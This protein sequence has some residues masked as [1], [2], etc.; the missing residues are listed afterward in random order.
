MKKTLK[1]I[2]TLV[3]SAAVLLSTLMCAIPVT[4]AT[5]DP[6]T[7]FMVGNY[8]I[9]VHYLHNKDTV[10]AAV[11][12]FKAANFAKQVNDA[13]AKWALFTLTQSNGVYNIPM[14]EH[15]DASGNAIFADT[16]VTVAEG[17][18]DIVE[19]LYDALAP[20]GIKLMLYWIP[21]APK[22][23]AEKATLLGATERVNGDEKDN[24]KINETVANNMSSIM[25]S[26]SD[27]YG[28]KVA[29]WWIDGCYDS[30]GFND[31]IATQEAAALRAG[32]ADALVAFNRGTKQHDAYY[33][34]ESYAAGEICHGDRTD[35]SKPNY[36]DIY[37]FSADSR[38]TDNGFQ[39]HYLTFLGSN[40]T[41]GDER[42]ET[43]EMVDHVYN[44]ILKN[45]GAMTFDM[46]CF[47]DGTLDKQQYNQMVALSKVV[48][49]VVDT[50]FSVNFEKYN[51][52][53]LVSNIYN[54]EDGKERDHY[55]PNSNYISV[56]TGEAA[57]NGNASLKVVPKDGNNRTDILAGT[58]VANAEA[59][60]GIGSKYIRFD[61][62]PDFNKADAENDFDKV[63]G[64]M[65]RVKIAN[66]TTQTAH[67]FSVYTYQDEYNK[68]TVLGNGAIAYD[69][70][71]NK[72]S[73]ATGNLRI[74]LPAGFDGFVFMPF[75]TAQSETV[76]VAG[77]YDKY[78][79]FPQNLIDFSNPFR[80]I[81]R[82]NDATWSGTEVYLDDIGFYY[83]NTDGDAWDTMRA[84]GYDVIN[85][86]QP[87]VY[88][89]PI[90][91]ENLW[92][93]ISGAK[94][95]SGSSTKW[96]LYDNPVK[97]TSNPEEVLNGKYSI[98][99]ST[100]N[101]SYNPAPL[102]LKLT[103]NPFNVKGIASLST[104]TV[105][106]K[107]VDSYAYLKVRVKVPEVASDIVGIIPAIKQNGSYWAMIKNVK[108]Y[109]SDGTL[110]SNV[111]NDTYQIK[112]PSGFDGYLYLPVY[113]MVS[114]TYN[115]GD[116]NL[117]PQ[118]DYI[119]KTE[120]LTAPDLDENFELF[121]QFV[122]ASGTD[123]DN[124]D[125][126]LDDIDMMVN[127]G[128]TLLDFEEHLELFPA[129]NNIYSGA[130]H[131]DTTGKGVDF[132][133]GTEALNG[134]GSVKFTLP[135]G[136]S[137]T[138]VQ[139][140]T[141]AGNPD[142]TAED[143]TKATGIM[144]RMKADSNMTKQSLF[145][146]MIT[147]NGVMTQMGR[148]AQLYSADG[149]YIG[150]A[151]TDY[152]GCYIPV[153]FDGFVFIPFSNLQTNGATKPDFSLP[154]NFGPRFY[155]NSWSGTTVYM[156]DIAYYSTASTDGVITDAEAWDIMRGLGYNVIHRI[157]PDV[158]TLPLTADDGMLPI[159]TI[160]GTANTGATYNCGTASLTTNADEV[161]NG[162]AS[163]K[164]ATTGAEAVPSGAARL[165]KAT[166]NI[167]NV[168][169]IADLSTQKIKAAASNDYAYI[170]LR[171]KLPETESELKL[172][173]AIAQNGS[174]WVAIK[175][176]KA[177]N[178]DG[179]YNTQVSADTLSINFPVGFDGY[180]EIPVYSILAATFSANGDR[181]L[182]PSGSQ[183]GTVADYVYQN[184]TSTAPELSNAFGMFFQFIGGGQSLANANIYLDDISVEINKP[185]VVEGDI[186]GD[187]EA[188][189]DDLVI[190]QK[191]LLGVDTAY[192][193]KCDLNL[194]NA[195]NI[196]DFIKLKKII[197]K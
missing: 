38:W 48:Y 137:E 64:I 75:A 157:Q 59:A 53:A 101:S 19:E 61:G 30:T 151:N 20:Y 124:V 159:T 168:N 110:N 108:G 128:N 126:Y 40:W 86:E 24:Y 142:Y 90:N 43:A 148:G 4:A 175:G 150:A 67:R 14:D 135:E 187:N 69:L 165:A 74:E 155:E 39:S 131:I 100:I 95:T 104:E 18:K 115:A 106:A 181:N 158:Y 47:D 134:N 119:Y 32:N 35:P 98:K 84:L 122:R 26:V 88:T 147:Q 167:F 44:N 192:E 172:I 63:S 191:Q 66:D 31:A 51:P 13:G 182:I 190:M 34:V 107:A 113:S 186:N 28:E 163:I 116:C 136:N 174:Y 79:T 6:A 109:N 130:E 22:D 70:E 162:K 55:Y 111:T 117:Q 152:W 3:L 97:L 179:S 140:I 145:T 184:E 114:A 56:V 127:D 94:A 112:M 16:D 169:G 160:T 46:S 83:G 87:D 80:M 166:T 15:L 156:D 132:V 133:T 146:I 11:N 141:L 5:A 154:Y 36:E 37:M 2:L 120:G 176:V 139:P 82:L 49:P 102:Y 68:P 77:S 173:P 76:T 96:A 138:R 85:I 50:A 185:A 60:N 99:I 105:K 9:M 23:N 164:L 195:V 81:I 52:F 72:V 62:N 89:L 27:K 196:L 149:T 42:Y 170:K 21:G 123:L 125:I 33:D 171:I 54:D 103:T 73:A 65:A 121:F 8:G 57:L 92:Q 1:K 197:G 129:L 177:Y 41:M 188:N 178:T 29:G 45:G 194:D 71:G 58:A 78:G 143:V 118:G 12:S 10:Q 91:S 153:G 17:R 161:L 180:I 183:S 25:A 193:D 93:P 7:D 144:F 189:G